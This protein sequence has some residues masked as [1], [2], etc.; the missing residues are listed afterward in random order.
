[1]AGGEY[2]DAGVTRG[3]LL[4]LV[5][6]TTRDATTGLSVAVGLAL[7]ILLLQPNP[8]SGQ[9]IRG[10]IRDT[11]TNAPVPDA[12]L[13][14]VAES[15]DTVAI[16]VS[17]EQGEFQVVAP[18]WGRFVVSI[19]RLGYGPVV[20]APQKLNP[21]DTLE[22]TYHLHPLAFPMNPVVVEAEAAVQLA[23]VR[24]L[25]SEGFYRRERSTGGRHLDPSTIDRRRDSAR[26]IDDFLTSLPG[27]RVNQS[28]RAG[29]PRRLMLR[30]GPPAFFIDGMRHRGGQIELAVDPY[31]VLAIE[32]YDGP[33]QA[34]EEYG[35]ACAVVLWTRHRA[36]ARLRP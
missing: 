11:T 22:I 27:V 35:G 8:A 24:Y 1:M 33:L 19:R 9:A 3:R 14:M 16:V 34:P 32:M 23:H 13:V 7:L 36:E 25:Q 2:E 28:S 12:R 17:D 15:G 20:R 30:C 5:T 29:A 21:S 4:T 10:F 26:Y 6:G 18:R 31:D